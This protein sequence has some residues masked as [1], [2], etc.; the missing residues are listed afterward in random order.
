M[1]QKTCTL[2]VETFFEI[3]AINTYVKNNICSIA[4]RQ[5]CLQAAVVGHLKPTVSFF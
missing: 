2:S 3:K 4:Q 5:I 1:M